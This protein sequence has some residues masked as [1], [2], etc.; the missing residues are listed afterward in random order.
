MEGIKQN[1]RALGSLLAGNVTGTAAAETVST[2]IDSK[3]AEATAA[4]SGMAAAPDATLLISYPYRM[5]TG[6]TLEGQLLAQVGF[7]CSGADYT[8]WLYPESEP[9][10]AGAGCDLLC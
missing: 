4:L 9:E 7:H 10:G 5:A 1:Y 2:A 6:D 8:N 3:L